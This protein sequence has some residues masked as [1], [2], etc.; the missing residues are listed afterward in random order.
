ME[1]MKRSIYYLRCVIYLIK[2][3]ITILLRGDIINPF[4]GSNSSEI[5]K[6]RML[7]CIS[8]SIGVLIA[9]E[10]FKYPDIVN[11]DMVG[12]FLHALK[13][14]A[15]QFTQGQLKKVEFCGVND[16]KFQIIHTEFLSYTFIT[17]HAFSRY[18]EDN[19]KDYAEA[20]ELEHYRDLICFNGDL[21]PFRDFKTFFMR[22]F[23][24]PARIL[25]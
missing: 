14:F 22:F 3:Y 5:Q 12:S 9:A 4:V 18:F 19:L 7:L 10:R 23:G 8:K 17:V 6:L 20:Y 16:L 11:F 21:T 2:W 25:S 15:L 24:V 1:L 13:V